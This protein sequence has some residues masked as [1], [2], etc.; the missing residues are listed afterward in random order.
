MDRF[1]DFNLLVEEAVDVYPT[2]KNETAFK[3]SHSGTD[4]SD[5]VTFEIAG[6]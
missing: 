6:T 3:L 5:K 1:T 2:M 4:L